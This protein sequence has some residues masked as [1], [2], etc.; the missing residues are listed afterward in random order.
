MK[1]FIYPN[2]DATIYEESVTR[3]SGI[4]QIL[5]LDHNLNENNVPY[6]SR[7][8]MDFDLTAISQSIANGTISNPKFFLR[9]F[10]V[11]AYEVPKSYTIEARPISGS[12]DMGL[13]KQKHDPLT[14]EGVSWRFRDGFTP[15]T[16]WLTGSYVAG[17]TG[18]Y[19]T[20]AGGGT[21]YTSSNYLGSQSFDYETTDVRLNVTNIVNDW[22]SN[23]IPQDGLI[24]KRTDESEASQ[25]IQ[26]E[27]RFF[28]LETNTIYI[29]RLEIAWN[30]A[31]F[32]TGSQT[33]ITVDDDI[34][35]HPKLKRNYKEGARTKIRMNVRPRF[36]QRT[37]TTS[38]NQLTEYY[39]PTSSYYQVR[40]AHT[41]DVLMDFDEYT[42]ISR[43][44]NGNYFNLWMDTFQPER[45]Y[46]LVF[47]V[48]DSNGNV[49]YYDNDY[50]FKVIK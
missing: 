24:I 39:L 6:N 1:T 43:D 3:N 8:L 42:Q 11:E 23:T 2:K 44:S 31:T 47:K 46:S 16:G 45:F 26:G 14:N 38:S 20:V 12:W 22:I 13:G 25:T 15:N 27:L 33:E 5:D 7:I 29:P 48:E 28:S 36:P 32:I 4:D 10:T 18:S 50:N 34:Q 30:D 17:S 41:Q 19:A 49:E 9:L 37:W 40:D 35:L 21:W